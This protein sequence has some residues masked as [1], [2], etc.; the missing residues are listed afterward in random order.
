MRSFY[1]C[2]QKR[3]CGERKGLPRTRHCEGPCGGSWAQMFHKDGPGRG[4]G[5]EDIRRIREARSRKT[6]RPQLSDRSR[7]RKVPASR[8]SRLANFGGLAVGLG[9]GALAE[10]AKKSLPGGR[11]PS[12]E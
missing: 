3:R 8:I 9:L 7:E 1:G 5:E 12:G 10:V 4:L 6:P 11:L 2:S